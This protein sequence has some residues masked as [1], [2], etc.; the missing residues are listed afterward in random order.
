M[1]PALVIRAVAVLPAPPVPEA[2][3]KNPVPTT[4]EAKGT[5]PVAVASAATLKVPLLLIAAAAERP[6]ETVCRTPAAEAVALIL[7][8]E[9]VP[10]AMAVAKTSNE[11]EVSFVK[12]AMELSA[13]PVIRC[14]T[15][16]A[17]ALASASR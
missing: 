12:V 11:A 1:S 13:L 17:S 4:A 15:P 6:P 5:L 16:R 3:W 14:Q 7:A 9:L 8:L 10:L 2:D